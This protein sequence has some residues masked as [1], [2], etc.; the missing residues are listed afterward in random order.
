MLSLA[1]RIKTPKNAAAHSCGT[2]TILGMISRLALLALLIAGCGDSK[3]SSNSTTQTPTPAPEPKAPVMNSEKAA[4]AA[5]LSDT[6][7]FDCAA[8]ADCLNSCEHGA[9]N[10]NWYRESEKLP[11]FVECEDGCSNQISAP[12]RCEGGTC[13]AYQ[14]DPKDSSTITKSDYCTRK[15]T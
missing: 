8:D 13:V 2:A 4:V 14:F 11:G 15:G 10:A 5:A 6:T 7:R 1:E 9:V 12:P 3:V